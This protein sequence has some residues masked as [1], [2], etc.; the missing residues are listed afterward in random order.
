MDVQE[1]IQKER[2]EYCWEYC[3]LP[4]DDEMIQCDKC[5]EWYHYKCV[6]LTPKMVKAIGDDE[7]ICRNC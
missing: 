1:V 6:N 7:W 3:Y 2:T 5:D 4:P